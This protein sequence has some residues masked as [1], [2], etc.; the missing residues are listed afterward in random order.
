MMGRNSEDQKHKMEA[1]GYI[2]MA[3]AAR[4]IGVD[5]STVWRW[6]QQQKVEATQVGDTWYVTR[7]SLAK[8]LGPEGAKALGVK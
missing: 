2:Q 5:Q 3:E 6:I 7:S 8:H 1:R 4:L